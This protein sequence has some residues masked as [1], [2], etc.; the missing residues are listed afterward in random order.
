[1]ETVASK[2]TML[3]L[4]LLYSLVGTCITIATKFF[5]ELGFVNKDNYKFQMDRHFSYAVGIPFE[6]LVQYQFHI[7]KTIDY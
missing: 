1:M 6:T 7:L 3:Y 2:Y 5:E 4:K